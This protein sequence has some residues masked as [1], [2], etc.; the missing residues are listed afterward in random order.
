METTLQ[1]PQWNDRW[2][3]TFYISAIVVAVIAGEW[4]HMIAKIAEVLF[5]SDRSYQSD[6][7]YH[8]E[9]GI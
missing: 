5:L 8:M 1:R 7:S 9:T 3:R 4:F 6:G 2:D